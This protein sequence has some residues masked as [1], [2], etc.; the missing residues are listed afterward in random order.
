VFKENKNLIKLI[1]FFIVGIYTTLAQSFQA[2]IFPS[3]FSIALIFYYRKKLFLLKRVLYANSFIVF[4]VLSLLIFEPSKETF[5]TATL[6]FFR[7]NLILIYTLFL[8][9]TISIVDYIKIFKNLGFPPTLITT[10][11]LSYR[12][13]GV[14]QEE[15]NKMKKSALCRGFEYKTNLNTYKTIGYMLG[16]LILKTHFKA[17]QIYKAIKCRFFL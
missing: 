9:T 7:A 6:I 11:I 13:L 17:L 14:I 12:Y 8:L 3:L 2:L 10:F 4:L 1:I 16:M 15:Y 5:L